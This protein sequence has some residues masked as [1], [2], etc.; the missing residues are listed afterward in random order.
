MATP[1]FAAGTSGAAGDEAPVPRVRYALPLPARGASSSSEASGSSSSAPSSALHTLPAPDLSSLLPSALLAANFSAVSPSALRSLASSLDRFLSALA[2]HAAAQ[3]RSRKAQAHD[4][5]ATLGELGEG[6]TP[7]AL[8][9]TVLKARSRA[10]P[11]SAA[12]STSARAPAA[13]PGWAHPDSAFLSA[14][15][16]SVIEA[17]LLSRGDASAAAQARRSR[18][19]AHAEIPAHLPPWP[20]AHTWRQTPVSAPLPQPRSVGKC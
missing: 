14:D 4:L 15:E 6:Y 9:R 12:A 20:A 11:V 19:E 8:R 3:A 7:A 16:E 13:E 5:V 2:A 1:L 10:R 18:I 17:E